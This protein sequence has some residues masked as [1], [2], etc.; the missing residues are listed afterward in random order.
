M[1]QISG[2]PNVATCKALERKSGVLSVVPPNG[3]TDLSLLAKFELLC[4]MH[5]RKTA[6]LSRYLLFNCQYANEA[7]FDKIII[8]PVYPKYDRTFGVV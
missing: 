6:V 4:G 3:I 2:S 1:H 5:K 7:V 8:P